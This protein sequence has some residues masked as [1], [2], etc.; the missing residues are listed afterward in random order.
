MAMA[1]LMSRT[2]Q[3]PSGGF[4]SLE[5]SLVLA[6]Y[7]KATGLEPY[8]GEIYI[9]PSGKIGISLEGELKLAKKEGHK[10]GVP[11][12]KPVER[13]WPAGMLMQRKNPAK[14]GTDLIDFKLDFDPGIECTILVDGEPS[15]YTAWFT[16]WFMPYNPNWWS[17]RTHM[18]MVRAESHALA[19][20]TG[21]SVSQETGAES[22]PE[23]KIAKT[24]VVAP[25]NIPPTSANIFNKAA[26]VLYPNAEDSV[27]MRQGSK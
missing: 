21:I 12:F 19:F 14:G 16:E 13:P 25:K 2:I 4:I 10:L 6:L 17:R 7:W 18:L 9:L 26:D 20:G 1:T 27:A 22:Q 8:K 23:P 15:V 5:Q 24:E 11:Q 3:N